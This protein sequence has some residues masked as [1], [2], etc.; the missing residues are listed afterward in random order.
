MKLAN[1]RASSSSSSSFTNN[2]DACSS[3]SLVGDSV[4]RPTHSLG[5][6][7]M[8]K[9][10]VI[11]YVPQIDS[12]C[13]RRS[14][15]CSQI[16]QGCLKQ[17]CK[18]VLPVASPSWPCERAHSIQSKH[19]RPR[20][21]RWLLNSVSVEMRFIASQPLPHSITYTY[22]NHSKQWFKVMK[23]CH[24]TEQNSACLAFRC[25]AHSASLGFRC[26]GAGLARCKR[27]SYWLHVCDF[28]FSI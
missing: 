22:W 9:L 1:N 4:F 28:N 10:T 5:T 2:C 6:A 15:C 18:A 16:L 25:T 26:T 14:K 20:C 7:G 12:G 24:A 13:E 19:P 21:V 27:S 8:Q 23:E 17:Q 3:R 11:I